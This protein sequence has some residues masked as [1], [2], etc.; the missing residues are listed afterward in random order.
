MSLWNQIRM[1]WLDLLSRQWWQW[2]SVCLVQIPVK[3]WVTLSFLAITLYRAAQKL[4]L[5]S[6]RK[7]YHPPLPHPHD[8]SIYATNFS[9]I[10]QLCPP[11]APPC[12]LRAVSKIK[13]NPGIG[14]VTLDFNILQYISRQILTGLEASGLEQSWTDSRK[15][16]WDRGRAMSFWMCLSAVTSCGLCKEWETK[17]PLAF[18]PSGPNPVVIQ[19]SAVEE[20]VS[21][22][23]A[24]L[25]HWNCFSAE[26]KEICWGG[27][28]SL[29]FTCHC[30]SMDVE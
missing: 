12:L 24:G 27:F 21:M 30:K 25:R 14:K 5:S 13:D 18:K 2:A 7:K 10:L 22:L 20:V 19:V 16:S 8:F 3:T 28:V 4:N 23:S 9:G 6:K 15:G 29:F 1:Q 11:P 26:V 17:F